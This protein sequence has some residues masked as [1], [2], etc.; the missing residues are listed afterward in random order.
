MHSCMLD[1]KYHTFHS[2]LERWG[3]IEV[4]GMDLASPSPDTGTSV[5]HLTSFIL[6]G[7]LTD[8]L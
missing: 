5:G 1:V 8:L 6:H 4:L 7:Y 2:N 3:R